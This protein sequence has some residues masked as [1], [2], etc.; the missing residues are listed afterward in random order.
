MTVKC[1]QLKT[2][3]Q[4]W[5]DMVC[6]ED[7]NLHFLGGLRNLLSQYP[8]TPCPWSYQ[9]R[10]QQKGTWARM[11]ECTRLN[12]TEVTVLRYDNN[13][14]LGYL[15]GTYNLTLFLHLYRHHTPDSCFEFLYQSV[16]ISF[17]R[18]VNLND[19]N[20]IPVVAVMAL[21]WTS[22]STVGVSQRIMARKVLVYFPRPVFGS[23]ANLHSEN[24]L[25]EYST[26]TG[27]SL[28]LA[29][30]SSEPPEWMIVF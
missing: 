17:C 19:S 22:H 21:T 8:R 29:C 7:Q 20:Q 16:V 13:M 30:H 12:F 2:K 11:H 1:P 6:W 25:R 15:P 14:R 3:Q 23:P 28:S 18:L 9:L 10:Q 5:G 26:E 4:F 27:V 24:G